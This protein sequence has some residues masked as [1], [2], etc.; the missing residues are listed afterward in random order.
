MG[1][2]FDAARGR[3]AR[4]QIVL[5]P[6]SCVPPSRLIGHLGPPRDH[7]GLA[8]GGWRARGSP[9]SVCIAAG[10]A[11]P[12]VHVAPQA[13]SKTP[14]VSRARC[15]PA[16]CPAPS[17][18]AHEGSLGHGRALAQL[19]GARRPAA[20]WPH[21]RLR[22]TDHVLAAGVPER[23]TLA[24]P[25]PPFASLVLILSFLPPA[26]ACCNRRAAGV[27]Q[28]PAARPCALVTATPLSPSPP[29]ALKSRP[30]STPPFPIMTRKPDRKRDTER[31]RHQRSPHQERLA[32]LARCT[33]SCHLAGCPPC[34]T[35][36]PPRGG[37]AL[38]VS[39]SCAP[40]TGQGPP[41][42]GGAC[43]PPPNPTPNQGGG[44][45]VGVAGRSSQPTRGSW[46]PRRSTDPNQGGGHLGGKAGRASLLPRDERVPPA[47]WQ[48]NPD[49]G[50]WEQPPDGNGGQSGRG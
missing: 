23:E 13:P 17:S 29:P 39:G 18:S 2:G 28:D 7:C 44:N 41:V 35:S 5:L 15:G 42:T 26:R 25:P 21:D 27:P 1:G 22:D 43:V 50:R 48:D 14:R 12:G 46:G 30:S 34:S 11:S 16:P 45:W 37:P 47:L 36:A 9:Q 8:G 40:P 6:V 10:E 31:R 4:D 20:L 49:G 3:P 33:C 38:A 24:A 32:V 19:A